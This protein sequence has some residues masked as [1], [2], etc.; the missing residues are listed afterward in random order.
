MPPSAGVF[1]AKDPGFY[2]QRAIGELVMLIRS[3]GLLALLGASS[4]ASAGTYYTNVP[5]TARLKAGVSL[6]QSCRDYYVQDDNA[7]RPLR[8]TGV[9]ALV[10]PNGTVAQAKITETSG[11]AELDQAFI[12]CLGSLGSIYDSVGPRATW[13]SVHINWAAIAKRTRGSNSNGAFFQLH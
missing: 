6:E 13:H 5:S 9:M 1:Q 10:M 2:T 7:P 3:I 8:A 4:L 12:N 11:S